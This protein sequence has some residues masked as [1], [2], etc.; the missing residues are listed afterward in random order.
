MFVAFVSISICFMIWMEVF[1]KY[2]LV[3]VGNVFL[4]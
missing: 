1:L 2:D 4:V 3:V